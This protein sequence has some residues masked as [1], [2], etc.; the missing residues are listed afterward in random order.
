[1]SRGH[2][3]AKIPEAEAHDDHNAI[4]NS[5]ASNSNQLSFPSRSLFTNSYSRVADEHDW[6]DIV[7]EGD[8]DEN[9]REDEDEAQFMLKPLSVSAMSEITIDPSIQST[10][11]TSSSLS[12]QVQM[13]TLGSGH[14]SRPQFPA[15]AGA[16]RIIQQTMDGVFSNLSAKPRVERPHQ[17]ELPPPYKS[18]A[19]DQSPAYFE[20]T[21]LAPGYSNDEVLVDGLPVGGLVGF[22]WNMITSMS[23]Q[24]VG[25]FL[26]YLLHTSHA[27][28]SGSKMGLG[29]TFISMGTQMMTGKADL[30]EGD[31]DLDTGYMGNTG[32]SMES[33]KEYLWLSYFMIALGSAIM[34]QSGIG[35]ARAKRT[36]MIINATSSSHAA[37]NEAAAESIA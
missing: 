23:F 30:E 27:T 15:A 19:L 21:V 35:F 13:P 9:N 3:Y 29:I 17:E 28:K 7:G 32:E 24:F 26:T 37:S 11:S 6:H 33:S 20:T 10:S 36:E 14:I 2:S 16:A 5:T 1:M 25:F 4:L 12:T 22:M 31:E 8:E 18:A 34:L